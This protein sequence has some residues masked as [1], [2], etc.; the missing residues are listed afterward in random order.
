MFR[1]FIFDWSGTL[2]DDMGPTLDATNAVL[3]QFGKEPM[4]WEEFRSRFRLPYSEFYEEMLP[5]VP[6][7]ELEDHFRAGFRDSGQ[8]VR[9]LEGTVEF[10]DWC[11]ENGVRM[12]VLTSMDADNFAS[13]VAAFGFEDH[14]EQSYAGVLDKR[15]VIHDILETHGLDP[16]ETGYVGDMVHD[17][18]TA[19]HGGVVPVGVLSGYDDIERLT[20][21]GPKFLL[22]CVKSLHAMLERSSRTGSRPLRGEDL[23]EIRKLR[24]STVIGVPDEER[25]AAQEVHVSLE[26]RPLRAFADL[27]DE[28][29]RTVDY[30][31]V[32]ERVKAVAAKGPRKLIETLADDIADTVVREFGVGEVTVTIEKFIL[33]DTDCV[34]VRTTRV[35]PQGISPN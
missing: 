24:V 25:A 5:G 6:L 21:A 30:G 22:S 33:A 14:F 28:V 23:I 8:A 13:Q 17:I 11:R 31:I 3:R 26:M 12:F 2:V 29:E 4:T 19:L 9:P 27:G 20:A 34:A 16:E 7:A 1:A 18:E 15:K 35:R 32:A 10:L